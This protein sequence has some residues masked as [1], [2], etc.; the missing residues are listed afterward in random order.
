MRKSIAV[1]LLAAVAVGTLQHARADVVVMTQNL[2]V[3]A[4]AGGVINAIA[5]GDPNAISAATA[6]FNALV[7]ATNFPARSE[8]L[9]NEIAYAQPTLI[10]LQEAALYR[11]GPIGGPANT[12]SLDFVGTLLNS[13]AARPALW[14]CR[15]R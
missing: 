2:Y 15:D 11:S 6:S 3:G 7:A 10:G 14:R 4:E 5:G 9:A 1:I 8:A 13:L 12:V